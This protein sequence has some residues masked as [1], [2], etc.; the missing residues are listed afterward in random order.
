MPASRNATAWIIGND[1]KSIKVKVAYICSILRFYLKQFARIR[2]KSAIVEPYLRRTSHLKQLPARNWS[3]QVNT[4][5]HPPT[6][7]IYQF[8]QKTSANAR[9]ARE[10]LMREAPSVE[11]GSGWYHEAAVQADNARITRRPRPV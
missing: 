4:N 8:P 7:K 1:Y 9:A 5:S 10:A 2:G 11:F 3:A 6:A